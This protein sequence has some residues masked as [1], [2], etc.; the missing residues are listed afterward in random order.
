[1]ILDDLELQSSVGIE[2][3]ADMF[4]QEALIPLTLSRRLKSPD[5]TPEDIFDCQL[6][7]KAYALRRQ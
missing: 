3:E 4:A 6:D 1:M 7:S 5:L 2:N